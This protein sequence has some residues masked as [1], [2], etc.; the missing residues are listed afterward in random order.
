MERSTGAASDGPM[1]TPER[2]SPD[3]LG[4]VAA[5]SAPVTWGLTGIFIRLLGHMD[6]LAIVV[7]RLLVGGF[8]LGPFVL[9]RG[10]GAGGARLWR[11][12]VA[13]GAYYVLAT[14]AFVRA[15]VVEVTLLVGTA[16]I[17]ALGI[18]RLRGRHVPR[19]QILG[20]I[21]ALIGL[22]AFLWPGRRQSDSRSLGDLLALG[23][24][25]VSAVYAI[26]IAEAARAGR[27]PNAFAVAAA[28]CLI[29]ALAGV[30]LM[31][32]GG[33]PPLRS[34]PAR[35]LG[36]MVMLGIISTAV[37]TVAYSTASARLPAVITTSLGLSTP[38]FAA[39]FAGWILG[40]WPA[41]SAVPA[42]LLTIAGLA[43][44]V[45][46]RPPGVRPEQNRRPRTARS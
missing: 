40:E 30:L 12:A 8:A 16:P 22:A 9:W 7:A 4:L 29:G 36:V 45:V 37:P 39:L 21:L 33:F 43:L 23:A 19:R 46:A 38:L 11:P 15:P 42:A 28:A 3:G 31:T 13:M 24:A 34:L 10:Q 44:V 17:I 35:D 14:E 2:S 41:A 5:L 26:G 25:T 6:P 27:A 18:E 32:V 1:H 20:V